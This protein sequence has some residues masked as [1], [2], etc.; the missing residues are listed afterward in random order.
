M[1]SYTTGIQQVGIGV[2]DAEDAKYLYRDLFGMNALVFDD[3]APAGLMT[4]YTGNQIYTRRALLTMNMNGG[5]GFEIWQFLSR[6]ATPQKNDFTRG[7]PGINAVKMKVHCTDTAYIYLKQYKDLV[8]TQIQSDPDNKKFFEVIDGYGNCFQLIEAYDWF[9]KNTHCFGGVT[10][11]IIGV[12]DMEKSI[13]FYQLLLGTAKLVYDIIET[14]EINGFRISR[15]RVLL[16][17][18]MLE[19]GAFTRLLGNTDIELIQ[20]M[21][22]RPQHL[23]HDR[24]WG[25]CGFIHICFDVLDMDALKK[26]M[27]ENGYVFTV[28]SASGFSMQDA[29]GRFCYVED[30][31]G[32]LIE[33]V[34]THKVPLVKKLGW[35]LQLNKRRTHKPLPNWMVSM[36]GWNK[37]K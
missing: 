28:D 22:E 12:T 15:R 5:G 32:T 18:T 9:Q 7:A 31:D 13:S 14:N 30:P 10:G 27:K 33:L 20:L 16:R 3:R 1:F 34:Q 29:A 2:T 23:F 17:K 6:A 8:I 4:A 35:Y 25:D 24:Y 21:D 11:A 26:V 37:V 36:L 19:K